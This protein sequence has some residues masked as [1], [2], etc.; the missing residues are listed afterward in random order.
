MKKN[1]LLALM[2]TSLVTLHLAPS[3]FAAVPVPMAWYIDAN[4][5]NSHPQSPNYGAGTSTSSVTF[6]WN[7]N[8]GY[9]FMPFFGAEFGYTKFGDTHIDVS[10]LGNAQAAKDRHYAYD[11]AGKAMAPFGES[12][13]EVFGKLGISRIHSH[14][15]VT[16][17]NNASSVTLNTVGSHNT[18]GLYLA[19]GTDYALTPNLTANL[20]WSRAKGNSTTGTLDLYSFGLSYLFC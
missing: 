15:T 17:A 11:I 20:Q 8:I 10:A 4:G 6:G 19:A 7:A 16:N 1:K 13:L 9:K 3:T 14:V 12:G 18:N 5:G 2:L